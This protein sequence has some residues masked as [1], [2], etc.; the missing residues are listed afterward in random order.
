M[1]D[2]LIAK[3]RH[4]ELVSG[5]RPPTVTLNLFQGLGKMPKQVRHDRWGM[6]SSPKHVTLNL[7]WG[8]VPPT[9]TLNLFQGLSKMPKQVRHDSATFVTLNV[10]QG[11]KMLNQVQHDV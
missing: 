11:L 10:V 7:L 9:V 5:S 8:L 1:G 3:A 2:A 4:P 6:H